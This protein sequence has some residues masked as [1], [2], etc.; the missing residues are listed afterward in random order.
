MKEERPLGA[1]KEFEGLL[2]G[3]VMAHISPFI[4]SR[5]LIVAHPGDSFF[6]VGSSKLE[7]NFMLIRFYRK[8]GT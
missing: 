1:G 3:V 7:R 2:R 8:K 6:T 5:S 4:Q